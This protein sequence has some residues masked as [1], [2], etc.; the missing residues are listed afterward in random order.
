MTYSA[1]LGTIA[2]LA[3]LDAVPAGLG[4]VGGG[5]GFL[6]ARPSRGALWVRLAPRGSGASIPAT[7]SPVRVEEFA[8]AAE[9]SCVGA[10]PPVV[11]RSSRMQCEPDQLEGATPAFHDLMEALLGAPGFVEARLLLDRSAGTRFTLS[12]WESREALEA[13]EALVAPQRAQIGEGI[14]VR[15]PVE[16]ELFEVVEVAV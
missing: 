8:V 4:P 3:W 7:L 15:R 9:A 12:L 1:P 2:T 11:A 6:L 13:S 16:V 10:G 5:S 14:R